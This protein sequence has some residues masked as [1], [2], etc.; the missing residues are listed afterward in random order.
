MLA[1]QQ[2]ARHQQQHLAGIMRRKL[3][4]YRCMK[5]TVYC[6]YAEQNELTF[7]LFDFKL[8]IRSSEVCICETV[9]SHFAEKGRLEV[10]SCSHRAPSLT[11]LSFT[12]HFVYREQRSIRAQGGWHTEGEGNGN[13]P[14]LWERHQPIIENVL[15]WHVTE[16][17]TKKKNPNKQKKGQCPTVQAQNPEKWFTHRHW[18]CAATFK[19]LYQ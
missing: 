9:R 1:H 11:S 18:C 10:I 17:E 8:N 4:Q 2:D 16:K 14:G 12:I 19:H 6:F 13:T 15:V 5:N 7:F 3:F